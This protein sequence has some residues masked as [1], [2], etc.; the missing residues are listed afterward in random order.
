MDKFNKAFN[1]TCVRKKI[2]SLNR[3]RRK[4]RRLKTKKKQV[5][6]CKNR[7]TKRKNKKIIQVQIG[8]STKRKHTFE[9]TP[10]PPKRQKV[11]N[12]S[13][14]QRNH[15]STWIGGFKEYVKQRFIEFK[16]GYELTDKLL[17][18]FIELLKL[19]GFAKL[20]LS[21]WNE[22]YQQIH[23]GTIRKSDLINF[24]FDSWYF[25]FDKH[26]SAALK[27]ILL[28]RTNYSQE[29]KQL[30]NSVN[31][32]LKKSNEETS[33]KNP[34]DLFIDFN[35]AMTLMI[36]N[37][38]KSLEGSLSDFKIS[39]K[40][41]IVLKPEEIKHINDLKFYSSSW[42]T[43]VKNPK[44]PQDTTV[45]TGCKIKCGTC[46]ICGNPIYIFFVILNE[47]PNEIFPL[48]VCGQDEHVLPVGLGQMFA[49]L[50]TKFDKK[51]DDIVENPLIQL[52]LRPSHAW[53]NQ[54]KN[55][56]LLIDVPDKT[57]SNFKIHE[58]ALSE[59]KK[60]AILWLSKNT[61]QG[62]K[63]DYDILFAKVDNPLKD[64]VKLLKGMETN[65]RK[66]LKRI[67]KIYQAT[68]GTRDYKD[69][70]MISQIK[71]LFNLCYFAKEDVL[72]ICY[73]H[74]L[75][76]QPT[77]I[78]SPK[79][80]QI[81]LTNSKT[82]VKAIWNVNIKVTEL[83]T[84]QKSDSLKKIINSHTRTESPKAME[85]NQQPALKSEQELQD[86]CF[87]IIIE[88]LKEQLFNREQENE[89][90]DDTKIYGIITRIKEGFEKMEE[91]EEYF[92]S[93]FGN[94]DIAEKDIEKIKQILKN[95]SPKRDLRDRTVTGPKLLNYLVDTEFLI[96][97]GNH[98][99][100]N[101]DSAL[102]NI[103]NSIHLSHF[104]SIPWGNEEIVEPSLSDVSI[105][106]EHNLGQNLKDELSEAKKYLKENKTILYESST[107]KSLS[108]L[109]FR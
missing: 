14:L 59:L 40:N 72:P 90:I 52:S 68:I 36:E 96:R 57:D 103:T 70:F 94:N 9:S 102:D 93:F 65:I 74:T 28:A 46:W 85:V 86:M 54:V 17:N 84:S 92:K 8:G 51:G 76:S 35:G 67:V 107:V 66:H 24:I 50:L 21:K 23:A 58:S 1:T 45:K 108:K 105:E 38:E 101:Q 11:P 31:E 10:P 27:K 77:P 100:L 109:F 34:K 87:N 55:N 98:Y 37:L 63:F 43:H 44:L 75:H 83:N 80:R 6:G 88:I 39:D 3:K 32:C 4:R 53:C 71:L 29:G 104:R 73:M 91:N 106:Q 89:L 95:I 5:G 48:N 19:R 30:S 97:Y 22:L 69:K 82:T 42:K 79:Q 18:D 56:L 64:K 12:T 60:K 81:Q 62:S 13:K 25:N 47:N 41:C 2:K 16:S 99:S 15:N 33:V 61:T 7:K 26:T 78:Q 20:D 49:T